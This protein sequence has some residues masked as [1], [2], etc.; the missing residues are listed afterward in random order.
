[1]GRKD[2]PAVAPPARRDRVVVGSGGAFVEPAPESIGRSISPCLTAIITASI[3][4]RAPTRMMIDAS[5]QRTVSGAR[6]RASATA[7]VL[8][9][10]ADR[11]RISCSCTVSRSDVRFAGAR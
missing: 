8:E 4:E 5:D 1:M 7:E 9:P 10:V 2:G 6:P 11:A 3:L